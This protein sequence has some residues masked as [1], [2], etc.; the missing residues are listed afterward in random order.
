MY[1]ATKRVVLPHVFMCF[2]VKKT[3]KKESA[4]VCCYLNLGLL[5]L[6]NKKEE[7]RNVVPRIKI[8]LQHNNRQR[9]E[10]IIIT[11]TPHYLF[12]VFSED[13]HYSKYFIVIYL[14]IFI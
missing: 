11:T 8:V 4:T 2:S 7:Q 12:F 9:M 1:R 6:I 13:I 5:C 3:I 10:F 14:C